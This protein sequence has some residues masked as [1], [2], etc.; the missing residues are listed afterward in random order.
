MRFE[1][2]INQ[3]GLLHVFRARSPRAS[4]RHHRGRDFVRSP[5]TSSSAAHTPFSPLSPCRVRLY[6]VNSSSETGSRAVCLATS[7]AG[8]LRKGLAQS[9]KRS[10]LLPNTIAH[11]A[12]NASH[13]EGI[14]YKAI[15]EVDWLLSNIPKLR[16][17]SDCLIQPSSVRNCGHHAP[18]CLTPAGSNVQC[19]K[20][21]SRSH[22]KGA[23]EAT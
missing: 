13:I 12:D 23:N 10:S 2:G 15:V 11:T 14:R 4:L 7:Y 21:T 5:S 6:S 16:D 17:S 18:Q 3:R 22:K 9:G 19:L 20:N 8:L 1:D